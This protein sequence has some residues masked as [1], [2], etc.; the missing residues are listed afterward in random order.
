MEP[1][2]DARDPTGKLARVAFRALEAGIPILA[3]QLGGQEIALCLRGAGEAV[4][5]AACEDDYVAGAHAIY[6][7]Y[8]TMTLMDGETNVRGYRW[9][10]LSD[11]TEEALGDALRTAGLVQGRYTNAGLCPLASMDFEAACVSC[12]ILG[13]RHR[14]SQAREI[15]RQRRCAEAERQRQAAGAWRPFR[16]V[17]SRDRKSIASVVMQTTLRVNGPG[18]VIMPPFCPARD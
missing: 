17:L 5:D 8:Q 1:G 16:W 7:R 10:A 13:V 3:F 9:M 2:E 11:P 18:T 15:R 4:G 14:E 12:A 6:R